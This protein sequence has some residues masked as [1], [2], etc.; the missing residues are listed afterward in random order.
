M[1]KLKTKLEK[2]EQAGNPQKQHML[3]H[4]NC[5]RDIYEQHTAKT[6]VKDIE[7]ARQYLSDSNPLHDQIDNL[8]KTSP[9]ISTFIFLQK[10]PVLLKLEHLNRS[11]IRD[12]K[13]NIVPAKGT[14]YI[15]AIDKFIT[16][17]IQSDHSFQDFEA[18]SDAFDQAL[19]DI[20]SHFNS[21]NI[22]KVNQEIPLSLN[23]AV[24]KLDQFVRFL[25][26]GQHLAV[27]EH[28]IDT[29]MSQKSQTLFQLYCRSNEFPDLKSCVKDAILTKTKQY[30]SCINDKISKVNGN[31]NQSKRLLNLYYSNKDM[32]K[33]SNQEVSD[34]FTT[35]NAKK[36]GF[37]VLYELS[38]QLPKSDPLK[39][40]LSKL[41]NSFKTL[42]ILSEYRPYKHS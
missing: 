13:L 1:Q 29:L 33:L 23:E 21:E 35:F 2:I 42:R 10:V 27:K 14:D 26:D 3:N 9:K 34:L 36:A 40:E 18:H 16:A 20:V 15:E 30:L 12:K 32:P 38:S 19:N 25:N 11:L 5:I 8:L 37:K 28:M 39:Q 22:N 6:F 41:F 31:S 4:Q 7:K 17:I 24:V